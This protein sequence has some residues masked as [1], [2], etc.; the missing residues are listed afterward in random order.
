MKLEC[1]WKYPIRFGNQLFSHFFVATRK[2]LNT[3]VV[4]HLKLYNFGFRQKLIWATIWN[5]F[6]KPVYFNLKDILN[7]LKL[8]FEEL[9]ISCVK[10]YFL[11]LTSTRLWFTM[12]LVI[13]QINFRCMMSGLISP[14]LYFKN[15]GRHSNL[16]G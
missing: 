1:I 15:L 4:R 16:L 2:T 6:L 7:I 9:V 12:M 14:A 3:K 5:S 11:S 13:C 8:W 10:F